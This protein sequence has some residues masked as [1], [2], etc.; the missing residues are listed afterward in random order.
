MKKIVFL[1][2]LSILSFSAFSQGRMYVS[3]NTGYALSTT[4]DAIGT[5]SKTFSNGD[6]KTAN[7][8]GSY[9]VGLPFTLRGGMKLNDNLAVELGASYL[10]GTKILKDEAIA[11]SSE[12]KTEVTSSQIR[13]L[14]SLI[15]SGKN[16][17]LHLYGRCG[18]ILPVGGKSKSEKVT[19]GPDLGG[20]SSK[21]V[22]KEEITYGFS[23]GYFGAIG[24]SVKVADNMHAFVEV[25]HISLNVKKKTNV[26]T[27]FSVNGSDQL[28]TLDIQ[29]KETVFVDEV[30]SGDNT[31]NSEPLKMRAEAVNF[32]TVGLNIGIKLFF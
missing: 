11:P 14:P 22:F 6:F 26:L 4:K 7:I 10:L 8:Y 24:A 31:K 25:E 29:Q 30:T 9:G 3:F 1:G 32:G 18:L 27:E 28:G 13:V 21:T 17:A 15:F 2:V 19:I 12:N 5:S 23:I 16:E 20:N